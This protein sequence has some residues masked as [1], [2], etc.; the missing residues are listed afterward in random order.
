MSRHYD[1]AIV[2]GGLVG[3]SL[4]VALAKANLNVTIALI[5]QVPPVTQVQASYDARSVALAHSSCQIFQSLD[6]LPA[7]QQCASAIEQVHVSEKGQFGFTRIKAQQVYLKTLGYV[8][9]IPKLLLL[10]SEA[11]AQLPQVQRIT[12][13]TV[14][15]LKRVDKQWQLNLVD[16]DDLQADLVIAAD[17]TL[18]PIRNMLAL[19]TK[20]SDYQQYAIV[21]NISINRDHKNIAYERFTPHGPLALLPLGENRVTLVCAI[22]KVQKNF[23]ESLSDTEFLELLSQWFGYRLG[24]F[25]KI[26]QRVMFPLRL[27]TAT[28][29]YK[30]GIVIIGNAAHNLHPIAAQGFNLGLRDAAFLAEVIADFYLAGKPLHDEHLLKHYY[31]L[32]QQDQRKT[33][34]FSDG[35]VKLFTN[36]VKPLTWIRN[37]GMVGLDVMPMAKKLFARYGMGSSGHSSRLARGVALDE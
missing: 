33:I 2:G 11:L 1:I 14:T 3:A 6:L 10:L 24:R 37:L 12:P 4:A 8:I 26:G 23:M 36:D 32:R 35:L 22:P 17:G 34:Q 28:E 7:I 13:A 18:S 29:Q 21:A 27:I 19:P 20:D 25:E 16:A 9:E 30:P 31:E 15:K 5:D